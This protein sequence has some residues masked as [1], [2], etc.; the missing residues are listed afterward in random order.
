M[1]TPVI[2]QSGRRASTV[3]FEQYH[4]TGQLSA[5]TTLIPREAG[6]VRCLAPSK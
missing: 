5:H 1:D 2:R 6:S 3:L 4:A